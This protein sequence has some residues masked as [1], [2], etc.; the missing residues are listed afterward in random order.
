MR[1]TMW[2]HVTKNKYS[3]PPKTETQIIVAPENPRPVAKA[4]TVAT[5]HV[6]PPLPVS[7]ETETRTGTTE[8]RPSPVSEN[9]NKNKTFGHGACGTDPARISA[10]AARSAGGTFG[11]ARARTK[12]TGCAPLSGPARRS[13]SAAAPKIVP[14]GAREHVERTQTSAAV[15]FGPPTRTQRPRR[16]T[17]DVAVTRAVP[18]RFARSPSCAGI[19]SYPVAPNPAGRD[20]VASR[21]RGRRP[22]RGRFTSEVPPRING[23]EP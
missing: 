9:K 11:T 12:R 15:V 10:V 21:I 1:V 17:R 5:E 4:L 20:N 8:P 19:S 18:E 3:L 6:R 23:P 22:F 13:S 14:S 7:T 16:C 2:V